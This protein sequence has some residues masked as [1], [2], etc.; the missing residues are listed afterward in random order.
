L[1][2]TTLPPARPETGFGVTRQ[3]LLRDIKHCPKIFI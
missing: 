3:I 1:I 2:S